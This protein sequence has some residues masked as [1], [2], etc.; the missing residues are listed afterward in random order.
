MNRV[1]IIGCGLVGA[2]IAYELSAIADL[3]ITVLDRHSPAQGSTGAALGVLMGVISQKKKGRAWRWRE[4]SLRTYEAWVPALEKA[5]G[6][7]IH[8]NRDGLVRLTFA[9]DDLEKWEALRAIRLEQGWDL[10]VWDR[11]QL[12]EQCPGI[13]E[14]MGDRQITGAIYSPCDRQV[15]PK[16]LTHGLVNASQ[17]RD[18]TFHFDANVCSFDLHRDGHSDGG[19][20]KRHPHIIHT[21]SESFRA[22]WVIIAAGLGAT[23][24]TQVMQ[25]PVDIRPVLGQALRIRLPQEF[26]MVQDNPFRP[27]VTG[28]DT[29]IIPLEQDKA[30]HAEYW[31]GATVEFPDD[32]GSVTANADMFQQ[33][34]ERAIAVYP[35]L[36]QAKVLEQWSGNRPRPFGRPAPIVEPMTGYS[37]VI[38]AAGHYRNGVLLAPAT[39]RIVKDMMGYEQAGYEQ[40]LLS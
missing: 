21:E 30:G 25:H 11:Q 20:A 15:D 31:V 14:R 13:G 8:F 12:D 10:A 24:L 19:I 29:H 34:W 6:Q 39:A 33:M 5:T 40:E 1:V 9:D 36:A 26:S 18:V 7:I 17:Q 2:A 22:D 38:L 28:N 35:A 4:H 16:A 32:E 3:D 23:G 37:Q 27:V